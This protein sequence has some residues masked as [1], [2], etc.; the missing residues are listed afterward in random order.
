[1]GDDSNKLVCRRRI[2]CPYCGREDDVGREFTLYFDP[3]IKDITS[4][5]IVW[6]CAYCSMEC[7]VGISI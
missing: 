1:M 6:R 4:D 7:V 5:R 2:P 3:E